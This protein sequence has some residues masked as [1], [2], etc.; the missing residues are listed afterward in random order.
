MI[1]RPPRS[2]LFPYTTLFRSLEALSAQAQAAALP[3]SAETLVAVDQILDRQREAHRKIVS[4]YERSRNEDYTKRPKY[5]EVRE[6]QDQ[7]AE[8]NSK[9][10]G[11]LDLEKEQ[12][13]HED[14]MREGKKLFGK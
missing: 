11:F 9:P 8:L 7:L 10:N 6:I 1:R 5:Q 2:T 14:W 4:L 13:R 12:K 3:V